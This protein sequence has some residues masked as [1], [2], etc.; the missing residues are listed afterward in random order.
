MWTYGHALNTSHFAH[1]HAL[2]LDTVLT[3]ITCVGVF[4][5]STQ[6]TVSK[7]LSSIYVRVT[8]W[9]VWL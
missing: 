1:S 6:V 8:E 7:E 9:Q 4:C 5:L 2:G 3:E